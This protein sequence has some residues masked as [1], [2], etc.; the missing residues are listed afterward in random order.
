MKSSTL[1]RFF[2]GAIVLACAVPSFAQDKS[3]TGET[4]L[5]I[6]QCQDIK[7][8]VLADGKE[9]DYFLYTVMP[10]KV[11]DERGGRLRI[12]D[13]LHEGWTDK[14]DFVLTREAVEYFGRLIS[15][16]PRDV[17]ARCMRGMAWAA[18]P[19]FLRTRYRVSEVLS[20]LMLVYVAL[21]V[22]NYLVSGPWKDPNGHNFP[23]TPPFTPAQLL[24][25][26]IPGTDIPPGFPSLGRQWPGKPPCDKGFFRPVR[27]AALSRSA[28]CHKVDSCRGSGGQGGHRS[29]R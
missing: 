18:I 26:A 7:L 28:P 19:A 9:A 22:L 10:M 20:T 11:R 17:W 12:H 13:S 23:Q 1:S 16:N 25:H 21:Q 2:A 6:K 29:C 24:P 5:P 27:G 8:S 15:A 14:R 3:W 4:V